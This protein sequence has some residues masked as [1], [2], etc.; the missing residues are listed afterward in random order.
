MGSRAITALLRAGLIFMGT[1]ALSMTSQWHLTKAG[2]AV[3]AEQGFSVV[4]PYE[5]FRLLMP[6]GTTKTLA[7]ARP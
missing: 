1:S 7:E 5:G 2:R 6:D 3:A 4:E